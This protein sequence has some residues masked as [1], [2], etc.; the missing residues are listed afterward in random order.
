VT[1]GVPEAAIDR[2]HPATTPPA[3]QSARPDSHHP[4]ST[5]RHHP[6]TTPPARQPDSPDSQPT[7]R[8]GI[9]QSWL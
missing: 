9:Q 3:R 7:R 6:A 1:G 4:A 2:H 8:V 5:D